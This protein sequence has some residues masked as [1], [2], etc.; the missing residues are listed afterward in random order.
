[1]YEELDSMVFVNG[2]ITVMAREPEH[3]KYRVL[4]HPQELMEDGEAYSSEAVRSYHAAWL[5]HLEH[6]RT[7]WDDNVK[8]LKLC[9][10][11]VWHRG[12]CCL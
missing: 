7:M 5:Q 10:D 1:M 9:R 4:L 2:Y 8:K 12:G 11:L 3:I 6:S